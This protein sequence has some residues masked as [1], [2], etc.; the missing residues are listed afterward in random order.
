[1]RPATDTVC[2]SSLSTRP[3]RF[4]VAPKASASGI[5]KVATAAASIPFVGH[6]TSSRVAPAKT[7]T[8]NATV[9]DQPNHCMRWRSSPR[10]LL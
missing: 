4:V 8:V 5:G 2:V 6:L 7:A 9:I 1:M 3:T 10:D